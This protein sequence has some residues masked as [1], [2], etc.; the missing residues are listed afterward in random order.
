MSL[1]VATCDYNEE[2][3]MYDNL[4]YGEELK[5]YDIGGIFQLVLKKE[6]NRYQGYY[7]VH[8]TKETFTYDGG[9]L[10]K[11]KILTAFWQKARSLG[12]TDL[13]FS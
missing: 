12:A 6:D 4:C 3:E 9:N 5:R 8:R 1:L 7:V 2:R 13:K 10:S 11:K